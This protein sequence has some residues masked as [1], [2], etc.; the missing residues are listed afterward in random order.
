MSTVVVM[1]FATITQLL[2]VEAIKA[3]IT[4]NIT[5]LLK[6]FGVSQ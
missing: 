6:K 5:K 2:H 3:G 4:V 1:I